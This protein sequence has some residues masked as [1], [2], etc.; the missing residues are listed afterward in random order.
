MRI[1]KTPS[2]LLPLG[3]FYYGHMFFS[4]GMPEARHRML[5]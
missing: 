3:G 5:V 1:Q 4:S 2:S